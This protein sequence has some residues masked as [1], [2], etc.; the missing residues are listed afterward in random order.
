MEEILNNRKIIEY[1]IQVQLKQIAKK[2]EK[3]L[4]DDQIKKMSKVIVDQISYGVIFGWLHK[5]VHS[6]GYH[7]IITIADSVNIESGTVASKLINLYI[8]TWHKKT[9]DL[10]K[11]KELHKNLKYE[12]NDQAICILKHIVARYIYMHPVP[13]NKKQKISA[14]LGFSIQQQRLTE[15][16]LQ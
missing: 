5:I 7:K 6:I 1:F 15:K 9:L 13:Y 4:S 3:D 11:I 16:K 2:R 8:H 14:L 10:E 12:K